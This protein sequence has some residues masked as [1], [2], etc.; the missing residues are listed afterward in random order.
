MKKTLVELNDEEFAKFLEELTEEELE[1]INK[2]ENDDILYD[3][4]AQAKKR[5]RG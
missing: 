5:I 3:T 1:K 4:T 2:K